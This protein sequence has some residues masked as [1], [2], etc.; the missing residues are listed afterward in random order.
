MKTEFEMTE[1]QLK[2]MMQAC[3]PVRYMVVGGIPPRST[4]ENAN[5]AWQSLGREMGFIWNTVEPSPRGERFFKAEPAEK[6]GD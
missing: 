6:G 5:A 3:Q 1:E 2:R 4:Q